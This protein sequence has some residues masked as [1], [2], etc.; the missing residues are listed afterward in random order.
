MR[1]DNISYRGTYNKSSSAVGVQLII[2]QSLAAPPPVT[3]SVPRTEG[4]GE[5]GD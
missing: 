5:R 3:P 1:V 2:T 4:E